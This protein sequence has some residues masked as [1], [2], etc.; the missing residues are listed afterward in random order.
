MTIET[1]INAILLGVIEGA[2]EY[3]PVSSTGHLIVFVDLLGFI[4]P[5]GKVFEIVIQVGAVLA[6]CLLY[7]GKLFGVLRDFTADPAARR[8]VYAILLAFLPA[9]VL[10]V[11]LHKYIKAY[12]FSPA[13]V[14]TTLILGGIAILVIE[15]LRPVPRVRSIEAFGPRLALGIG[16]IQCIAMIPGVSR[17]GATIL[18]ALLLG[19]E[20]K[21]A[22]EFS[23]FLAIPTLFGAAVYDLWSNRESL[24]G[25]GALL[26]LIGFAAAFVTAMLVVRWMIDFVS[27]NGFGLF[28]WYRI[29]FGLGLAVILWMR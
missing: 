18:G 24:T 25:D 28:A 4:G 23:F 17:S 19:V 8:F 21:T 2:T 11:L 3:L 10:G 5:P 14:A 9:A 16:L 26:L 7:F 22:A 20:R 27:R 1:I 12:L 29:V 6:V 15:R 13:V